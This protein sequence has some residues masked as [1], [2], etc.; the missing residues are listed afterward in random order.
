[1]EKTT[2]C[3][4]KHLAFYLFS[5]LG[6]LLFF[7]STETYAVHYA[8]EYQQEAKDGLRN[9]FL[10]FQEDMILFEKGE[11]KG[12]EVFNLL[13]SPE[14]ITESQKF[15]YLMSA[16]K[17]LF[18]VTQSLI[19]NYETDIPD[20][21]IDS[22][23]IT[24]S[25]HTENQTE[26]HFTLIQNFD[27][28]WVFS[29]KTLEDTN[30]LEFY[31]KRKDQL[32]KL[33]DVNM[34]GDTFSPHLMSPYHTM[35]TLESAV[36]GLYGM[37]LQNAVQTLD[38]SSI[39]PTLHDEIGE[40][41]AVRLYRIIRFNSPVD[42]ENLSA[43]PQSETTPIFLVE[44]GY[45]VISM[46]VVKNEEGIK[47]WKF[48]P[49]SLDITR[50][51][52]AENIDLFIDQGLNPF[53]GKNL[54]ISIIVDDFVYTK[55]PKLQKSFLGI[56][57]WK[58]ALA[59]ITT[60]I[61]FCVALF[62][63]ILIRRVLKSLRSRSVKALDGV[64]DLGV[65]LPL[66]FFISFAICYF[67]SPILITNENR[68]VSIL[69]FLDT[70]YT[71]SSVWLLITI[72]ALFTR[73]FSSKSAGQSRTT[74]MQVVGQII[75]TIIILSGIFH[76]AEIFGQDS[77][78]VL[79]ALGIGGVAIAL[80]GK[81]TVE[82]IF[83]TIMVITSQPFAL[84]DYIIIDDIQGEVEHV[85]LRSTAIRTFH[86]SLMTVPNSHFVTS[87]IDNLGK[88]KY[89]RLKTNLGVAYDTPPEK[90]IA[91]T[92]GLKDLAH[93][94]P[95]IDNNRI[96]ISVYDFAASSIDILLY[97]HFHVST[98]S[99]ELKLRERFLL[100]A[101]YLAQK[102]GVEY[103]FPTRTL[104]LRNEESPSHEGFENERNCARLGK[105][106]ASLILK[107]TERRE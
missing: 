98:R 81:H 3:P 101:L 96:Y 35:L 60:C 86:N 2:T 14:N 12:T 22:D 18:L 6:C 65:S 31:K 84:G 16:A 102:L 48:T 15:S 71:L 77:T 67:T 56:E 62:L 34:E 103:A 20:A 47:A 51:A 43:N 52:Y 61:I 69:L 75:N 40:L 23:S 97:V 49:K 41:L 5:I 17:R 76:I 44:P 88:R 53:I 85:G 91:F 25:L 107:N 32:T 10:S 26:I 38:L 45:G 82:N 89:R 59:C 74:I 19:F 63:K 104:Y 57:L 37:T 106:A 36:M 79:T 42:I 64:S 68:A 80:A 66:I 21:P 33:T 29:S 50:E 83:G 8:Q 72:I 30:I 1:M 105:E 55:F 95:K 93:T 28:Q 100:D 92:E 27:K 24:F 46:H 54:P 9:C 4:Y 78:R 94:H 13:E 73:W 87:N 58:Y 99:E 70:F 7:S 90:L 11:S 39:T